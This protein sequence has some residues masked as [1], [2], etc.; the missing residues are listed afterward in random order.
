MFMKVT[1][2]KITS[3]WYDGTVA[4]FLFVMLLCYL[5]LWLFMR[6]IYADDTKELNGL[7][8]RMQDNMQS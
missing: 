4:V 7:L 1:T 8:R 6:W 3:D 5:L 2:Q